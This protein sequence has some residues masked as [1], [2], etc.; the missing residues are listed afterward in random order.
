MAEKVQQQ[1]YPPPQANPYG[2][3]DEEVASVAGKDLRRKKRM[4]CFIYIVIFAL[5][6]TGIILLFALTI[7]KLRTPKF[8]V[9][10]ATFEN[11]STETTNTSFNI[12][13]IT[14]VGVKNT[15][16]GS[17]KYSQSSIDFYY[18]GTKVGEAL[19]PNARAKLRST[20]KFDVMVD[21]TSLNVPSNSELG[22]DI[23]SGLLPLTSQSSLRGKVELMYVMKRKK[24]T[25]MNCSMV[26]NIQT[27]QLQDVICR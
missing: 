10:S 27:K 17:Y 16:F 6:Q 8:R 25:N 19:V 26:I 2:R 15:N 21:L 22:R 14:E 3:A 4:K 1:T 9:R 12:R 20:R 7:M 13:M 18:K 24:S 5:F 23:S 11:F